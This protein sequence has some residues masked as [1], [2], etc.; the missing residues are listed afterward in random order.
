MLRGIEEGKV[1]SGVAVAGLDVQ[2]ALVVDVVVVVIVELSSEDLTN[3]LVGI[4]TAHVF[5][6]IEALVTTALEGVVVVL[7]EE[8]AIAANLGRA[9]EWCQVAAFSVGWGADVV[10][11]GGF[12]NVS[13]A[14]TAAGVDLDEIGD[15]L[16]A[17]SLGV[18]IVA[19]GSTASKAVG[20]VLSD[21]ISVTADLSVG[22]KGLEGSFAASEGG[23]TGDLTF[24]EGNGDIVSKLV[25][26]SDSVGG[27]AASLLCWIVGR[28]TAALEDIVVAADNAWA[29][30][31]ATAKLGI[32]KSA[33]AT[34]LLGLGK[35]VGNDVVVGGDG[36]TRAI[37]LGGG[38]GAAQVL[39]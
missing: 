16:L 10:F 23:A 36:G 34:A 6:G 30:S 28:V 25:S 19:S 12:Y 32:V 11:N 22:V 3:D 8:V 31:G 1:V 24:V 18:C 5:V 14:T 38:G 39:G 35:T 15:L 4:G 20:V 17:A 13:R 7:G 21:N 9:V 29:V 27:R 2:A 26:V 33:V 37:N